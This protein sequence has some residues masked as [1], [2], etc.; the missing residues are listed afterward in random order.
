MLSIV[1]RILART[2]PAQAGKKYWT[3]RPVLASLAA[4]PV[5]AAVK[6][7]C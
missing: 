3:P 4:S 7:A 2:R 6:R 1:T 5:L